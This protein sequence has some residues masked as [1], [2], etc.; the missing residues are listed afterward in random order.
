MAGKA[1]LDMQRSL[2][3]RGSAKSIPLEAIGRTQFELLGEEHLDEFVAFLFRVYRDAY[4]HI[5]VYMQQ[6]QR[7]R[8]AED[9]HRYFAETKIYIA[10]LEDRRIIA[11][12]GNI[13]Q[14]TD[15]LLPIEKLFCLSIAGYAEDIGIAPKL[16][17]QTW[18]VGGDG[19]LFRELG[20]ST[21]DKKALFLRL[22]AL[23]VSDFGN[24]DDNLVC[25]YSY[26]PA[27]KLDKQLGFP[28]RIIG[29]TRLSR[30]GVP[31]FPMA[32]T[33][34]EWKARNRDNLLQQ[35]H[36]PSADSKARPNCP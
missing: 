35:N 4:A 21:A 31:S 6:E 32:F 27:W 12:Y 3:G 15:Q 7:Q 2:K 19:G 28:W 18:R 11:S 30:L 16:I 25:G 22:H 13:V 9:T 5:G 24:D 23:N 26:N 29:E 34:R 1:S 14:K 33:I 20:F 36:T 8:F 10:R 17:H